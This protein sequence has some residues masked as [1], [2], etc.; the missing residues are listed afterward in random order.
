[1]IIGITG[2]SGS[3]KSTVA[4]FLL[5][6]TNTYIIESD[7]VFYDLLKNENFN[8]KIKKI[9]PEEMHE[10]MDYLTIE[11]YVQKDKEIYKKYHNVIKQQIEDT[12]I[13]NID[14]QE[15]DFKI[16]VDTFLIERKK[17]KEKCDYII[18]VITPEW[19]RIQRLMARDNI[20]IEDAAQRVNIQK[21]LNYYLNNSNYTLSNSMNG[22]EDLEENIISTLEQLL[23]DDEIKNMN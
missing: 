1:M 23:L 7:E 8:K 15:N 22:M 14:S 19:Q 20:S 10:K 3:G 9:I 2:G 17:L 4:E 21:D 18:S 6:N 13:K 12:I 11:N 5:N 16:I